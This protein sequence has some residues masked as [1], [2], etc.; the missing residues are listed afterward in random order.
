VTKIRSRIADRLQDCIVVVLV[1]AA[2]GFAATA[3]QAERDSAWGEVA[4]VDAPSLVCTNVDAAY[5]VGCL[6]TAAAITLKR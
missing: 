3:S 6:Q 2:I 4:V 1:V 5:R